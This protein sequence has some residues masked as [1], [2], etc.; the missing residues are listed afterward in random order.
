MKIDFKDAFLFF[1]RCYIVKLAFIDV[2]NLICTKANIKL[3]ILTLEILVGLLKT[4]LWRVLL[5]V[6]TPLRYFNK[7]TSPRYKPINTNDIGI[8]CP[9]SQTCKNH[10]PYFF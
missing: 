2:S 5:V 9:N 10:N 6:N 8:S 4:L 3:T 1:F 7:Y